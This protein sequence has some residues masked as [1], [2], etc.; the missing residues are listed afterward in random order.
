[1]YFAANASYS[2]ALGNWNAIMLTKVITGRYCQGRHNMTWQEVSACGC[3]CSVDN[4]N[5]PREFVVYHDA[6]AYPEYIIEYEKPVPLTA[7]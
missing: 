5:D 7:W 1:M 4:Y 3:Y 6:A 2:V